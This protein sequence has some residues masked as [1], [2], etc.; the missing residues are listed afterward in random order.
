MIKQNTKLRNN[1]IFGKS[2][3]N[4]MNKVD[5]KTVTTEEQYLSS[6][7]DEDL[8][9]KFFLQCSSSYQKRKV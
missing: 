4:P 8:K 6:N 2:M 1:A 7:L 9:E 3:E 5:V